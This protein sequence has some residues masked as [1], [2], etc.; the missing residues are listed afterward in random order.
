MV[1]AGAL[2]D[3]LFFHQDTAYQWWSNAFLVVLF[4]PLFYF[5]KLELFCLAFVLS[6]LALRIYFL[7]AFNSRNDMP[8]FWIAA[9]LL[10]LEWGPQ[11]F[12][13]MPRF[14]D[15]EKLRVIYAM[16]GIFYLEAALFKLGNLHAWLSGSLLGEVFAYRNLYLEG[17]GVLM[18][19]AWGLSTGVS[20]LLSWGTLS[21]ELGFL[22]AAFLAR[23]R[24]FLLLAGLIFH[25][26]IDLILH[27]GYSPFY[28]AM[29]V[30][31]L[32]VEAGMLRLREPAPAAET[33]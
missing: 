33:W 8:T 27:I 24:V 32:I 5:R 18:I 12:R 16:L 4:A 7:P 20:K 19:P 13:R 28:L 31:L 29:L 10:L 21:F 17:T 6:R 26:A 11:A 1:F 30:P 2:G 22:A 14:S 23:T 25:A 15:P 3:Q 9:M